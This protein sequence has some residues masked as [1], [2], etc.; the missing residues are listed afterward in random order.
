MYF[1]QALVL[2][3]AVVWTSSVAAQSFGQ[4]IVF[5]DS[6]VDSGYFKSLSSPG[7]GNANYNALWAAAVASGAGAPTTNP[8]LMN[9]QVLA[10]YF[11][12]TALPASQPGGTNY[13]TSGA[14]NVL[15]NG[16]DGSLTGGFGA[17]IP[18]VTQIEGYL[19]LNNGRANSGGLYLIS[20]G[21]NDV[22]YA[23]S[24]LP[25]HPT[26]AAVYLA[27][28]ANGLATEIAHL[29]AAGA[30]Y[31]IV[32]DLN[33]SFPKNNPALQQARLAYSQALWSGLAAQ[34]VKFIPADF[35]AV[36]LAIDANPAAFGFITTSNATG[37]TACSKPAGVTTAWSLL[38][39]SNP[40][41]PSHLVSADAD[42][43]HLFADDSHMTMAGQ[44]IQADY[45][46][47]LIVAPSQISLLAENAVVSRLGTVAGIQEQIDIARR[48]PNSGF[49]LWINGDIASLKIGNPAPGFPGD[50]GTPFFG[51]V[52]MDYKGQQG[53]L[54]GAAITTG[55]QT[56]GFEHGGRFKQNEIAGSLYAGYA[57]GR[58]WASVIAT[59]GALRY[60]VNRIV[61]I[62]ITLQDNKGG[63]DGSNVSLAALGGTEF[64]IGALAHGPVVGLT[65]QRVR[66]GAFTETGGF[67]S[68][69]FGDQTRDSA[70]SALGYRAS[71]DLG[72]V[73]PFAQI[74]WNHE[75]ASNDRL[76]RA[77]LTTI[78]APSY[79]MP[80]AKPGKDWATATLGTTMKFTG[81]LTGL[82]T[83]SAQ[84]GQ[85][86]V[87][88][89]G[90]R[91]GLNYAFD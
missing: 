91:V 50:S 7:A 52:G 28:A 85:T 61:P 78:D 45:F 20:S 74:V 12:L 1:R 72:R 11:G 14:K 90:G 82:A 87:M 15:V 60:D 68:L 39:S 30:R 65:L 47:S 55:A 46:Y 69:G 64:T 88:T 43:T 54:L 80:A 70:I 71:A 29:Q 77:S 2:A 42:Q 56:P 53:L 44:K 31:I 89:Y 5:G 4:A 10:A 26:N 27:D 63:T 3:S 23:F 9:S 48:R 57:S 79:E 35:N 13:A 58:S 21:E 8:G 40:G 17:A 6:N 36:R 41:A 24:N 37:S 33:F 16:P 86:G 22:T 34:G 76:V 18:T 51:T 59:Y 66:V 83:I 49:N 67:T 38:C 19:A 81:G 25:G 62:G 73:R 84:A 32:P 75:L